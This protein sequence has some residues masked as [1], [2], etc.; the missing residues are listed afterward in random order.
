MKMWFYV[1][2]ESD[3]IALTALWTDW[4]ARL[5]RAGHGITIIPLS[6]KSQFLRK[7]GHRAGRILYDN[8]QDVVIGLPD[9]YPN[10]QF[11]TTKYKHQD[12]DELKHV[13]IKQVS[14]ALKTVFN[15]NQ[16]GTKELL[17]RFLP[18]ALKH[19]L[20]MLL[21]AAREQLRSHLG[22]LDQLGSWLNPVEEQNQNQPPKHIVQEL[23]RTKS[24]RKRAYRDTKDAS[25][26]LGKV[27]D[28]KTIIYDS[29]GR[30]QCPLFKEMLDWVGSKAGVPAYS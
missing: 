2:G 20:E 8:D 14:E 9:L 27:T 18:S 19:D 29:K 10:K 22:T 4:I 1:E 23:F 26:I 12:L 6:N 25:A 16:T 3:K 13:Q 5:R 24:A 7:I 28:M 21:L 15:V 30:V 17:K 11:D